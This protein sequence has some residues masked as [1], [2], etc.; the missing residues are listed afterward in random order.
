MTFVT[1]ETF[2]NVL[3]RWK[4]V[5]SLT[6]LF[7]VTD[8]H[9]R[10]VEDLEADV[11]LGPVDYNPQSVLDVLKEHDGDGDS[12]EEKAAVS[13]VANVRSIMGLDVE[14]KIVNK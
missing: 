10:E 11:A 3:K 8:N 4:H 14:E 5:L 1:L 2:S 12:D 13:T 6:I 9:Y 7:T